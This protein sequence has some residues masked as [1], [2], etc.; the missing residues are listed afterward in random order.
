MLYFIFLCNYILAL[1]ES[2]NSAGYGWSTSNRFG[3]DN[4]TTDQGQALNIYQHL[5]SQ[6]NTGDVPAAAHEE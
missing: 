2:E 3:I 6:N 4:N 5:I 1:D